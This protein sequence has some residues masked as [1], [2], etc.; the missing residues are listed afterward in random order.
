MI[1][2]V[3]LHHRLPCQE[4]SFL[5]KVVKRLLSSRK[6]ESRHARSKKGSYRVQLSRVW[7]PISE[8]GSHQ[9]NGSRRCIN[10]LS[11]EVFYRN[12]SYNMEIKVI[13]M[14][15]EAINFHQ[16]NV[17]LQAR[18]KLQELLNLIEQDQRR[19]EM[20][21]TKYTWEVVNRGRDIY[22]EENVK[23]SV[24]HGII[25]LDSS[26][27]GAQFY[28][29]FLN[30]LAA[31][32]LELS[33]FQIASAIF[34]ILINL[35]RNSSATSRGRD[36]AAAL[37]NRGCILMIMACFNEA[38]E[39]FL[40]ALELFNVEK[41]TY[42]YGVD[43]LILAVKNNISRLNMMLKSFEYLEK[44]EKLG[45]ECKLEKSDVPFQTVFTVMHNE[46]EMHI[47]L[48]NLS[49]AE[50]ELR[51]LEQYLNTRKKGKSDFLFEYTMLQLSKVLLL[52]GKERDAREVF[53][54]EPPTS[55]SVHKL[56]FFGSNVYVGIEVFEKILDLSVTSGK[57]K[58]ARELLDEGLQVVESAFGPDHFNV[59]SLL[60]KEGVI[61]KMMGEM[62][63][64]KRKLEKAVHI[65]RSI[66]GELHP[67]LIKCYMVLG[68]V[69]SHLKRS[70]EAYDYFQ[71]AIKNVE[72]VFKVS[73]SDQLFSGDWSLSRK[74]CYTMEQK[75]DRI[76]DLV[77]EYG[78]A[79]AVV[80]SQFT[81]R[82]AYRQ[83]KSK[84]KQ[85][86]VRRYFSTQHHEYIYFHHLLGSG[87]A[88]ARQGK[89]KEA[90]TFFQR[91]SEFSYRHNV[92]RSLPE[93]PLVRLYAIACHKTS[94]EETKGQIRDAFNSCFEEISANKRYDVGG[95]SSE[96]TLEPG[97]GL[98]LKVLLILII[99]LSLQLKMHD[100]TFEA[101]DLYNSL[102]QSHEEIFSV[103]D[104]I[105]VYASRSSLTCNG[106]TVLQ[107]FLFCSGNNF[108]DEV[109]PE[110]NVRCEPLYKSLASKKNGSRHSLLASYTDSNFLDIEDLKRVEEK[111]LLS[112]KAVC[113]GLCL[114][115]DV[116]AT[117][118]VVDLSLTSRF[119]VELPAL[120]SCRIELLPLCLTYGRI[121]EEV[122]KGK[123]ICEI[124]P[125][126]CEKIT[127]IAFLDE[128]MSY[129]MFSRIGI[130]LLK[131]CDSEKISL[132]VVQKQC[133]VI[134]I[135][136]PF[137]VRLVLLHK[138]NAIKLNVQAVSTT[139]MFGK[140]EAPG[141]F[142]F[143]VFQKYN[144]AAFLKT[145]FHLMVTETSHELCRCP[146]ACQTN[147]SSPRE[148]HE[149]EMKFLGKEETYTGPFTKETDRS[150]GFVDVN[151]LEC[152][153]AIS[154]LSW[155]LYENCTAHE[156]GNAFEQDYEIQTDR[157]SHLQDES[158]VTSLS[159]PTMSSHQTERISSSL[160]NVT[161]AAEKSPKPA[162]MRGHPLA[163][164]DRNDESLDDT[165]KAMCLNSDAKILGTKLFEEGKIARGFVI[166]QIQEGLRKKE[167]P[168]QIN[169]FQSRESSSGISLEGDLSSLKDHPFYDANGCGPSNNALIK[170]NPERAL[171]VDL[172]SG[173]NNH[174]VGAETVREG[175]T[176]PFDDSDIKS[177][178]HPI[179][180]DELQN[181][182]AESVQ[183]LPL[184]ISFPK[185]STITA[186]K[187]Y[188]DASD[189][190]VWQRK[191]SDEISKVTSVELEFAETCATTGVEAFL[192]SNDTEE[193]HFTEAPAIRDRVQQKSTSLL[194]CEAFLRKLGS[195][196][197]LSSSEHDTASV[198]NW[199]TPPESV[200][201]G[202]VCVDEWSLS[203][204]AFPAKRTI[205]VDPTPSNFSRQVL[206]CEVEADCHT[207]PTFLQDEV[208]SERP[209]NKPLNFCT[210]YG[211]QTTTPGSKSVVEFRNVEDFKGESD[212]SQSFTIKQKLVGISG[213]HY[214]SETANR[215]SKSFVAFIHGEDF[216]GESD[217]AQSFKTEQTLVGVTGNADVSSPARDMICGLRGGSPKSFEDFSSLDPLLI[218]ETEGGSV[219]L[220]PE[221]VERHS[222]TS[223]S[224]PS[225][226]TH[227]NSNLATWD[228]PQDWRSD[229][230]YSLPSFSRGASDV[231]RLRPLGSHRQQREKHSSELK[232]ISLEQDE[233]WH[234]P[235]L[236]ENYE[237]NIAAFQS[238]PRH[239]RCNDI[240]YS[241]HQPDPSLDPAEFRGGFYNMT[242]LMPKCVGGE[243]LDEY[244]GVSSVT[245][246]ALQ[247]DEG[248]CDTS[249]DSIGF[250]LGDLERALDR[251]LELWAFSNIETTPV[252][253]ERTPVEKFSEEEQ[254]PI[255]RE[256][257]NNESSRDMSSSS[258][259]AL[260]QE[261]EHASE[262][263][264]E[265]VRSPVQETPRPL[266][267]HYHRRCLV[268]FPCCNKFYPCHRCHNESDEC[269][270][271]QSRAVN[272]THLRCSICYNEQEVRSSLLSFIRDDVEFYPCNRIHSD[273]SYHCD[274]CNVCLDKRLLGNH[275]CRPDSGHDECCICLEDAFS[276]C[277]I[278]PCSHKVHKDCAIAMIENG[279]RSCPVCR[280]PLFQPVV[281]DT[282]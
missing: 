142:C 17:P 159:L 218:Q 172:S 3:V 57:F 226:C 22:F 108:L 147:Q 238:R 179:R 219:G 12:D 66:F 221:F 31:F 56:I 122:L 262:T 143:T 82:K 134:I 76:D 45:K 101:H 15:E 198:E 77:A 43:A 186:E 229:S 165:N 30:I 202:L 211:S 24:K 177:E 196:D 187:T 72:S 107:D 16:S 19:S 105:Q 128:T 241:I 96:D 121:S 239:L 106:E 237:D 92:K 131:Q 73:F 27:G 190:V 50:E 20:N 124:S 225:I 32:S 251:N 214:E 255:F 213:T 132:S 266:C 48:G 152:L 74:R 228:L 60:Y 243:I 41:E 64:S 139:D 4:P 123:T 93:A 51:Q 112:F 1:P 200:S 47:K 270:E 86:L 52:R 116:H 98:N 54:L 97:C 125:R 180:L 248:A 162:F 227:P 150:E 46:I 217:D 203:F 277:Q 62:H 278:L 104:Q 175:S 173:E 166:S 114:E 26:N 189:G 127:R 110:C 87:R 183:E 232:Q 75:F 146:S 222:V 254:T 109:H 205:C 14:F 90:E 276:G 69:A 197:S 245:D 169:S 265:S 182:M 130:W 199:T 148:M 259:T 144:A 138:G 18:Y 274:V 58:A 102:S 167:I 39:S 120:M 63:G 115:R 151:T 171:K 133:I 88:L 149:M 28:E 185:D 209:E 252:A 170:A 55:S 230:V 117:Q 65:V 164:P 83:G 111:T 91:A 273:K 71:R 201:N 280:H 193:L 163:N 215:G 234:F 194:T 155:C 160:A 235:P 118:V 181:E 94:P 119:G 99:I 59:A 141:N 195:A 223:T 13:K 204:E 103:T 8:N 206:D 6:D 10:R 135:T 156:E 184:N 191:A 145:K 29:S 34:S 192:S 256:N 113:G 268:K 216:K 67:L 79:L 70:D 244:S 36:L 233:S 267:G 42:D 246:K 49:K 264:G 158:F 282:E 207:N 208:I 281:S 25:I 33:E 40:G 85:P 153:K 168:E 272:A 279:V 258:E 89:M 249:E 2:L 174:L 263:V 176:H 269:P 250:L 261:N 126:V 35:H 81:I 220:H 231:E 21:R 68:D 271:S 236:P 37:N 275:K 95:G 140:E 100:T 7:S 61:L 157:Q 53:A 210:H 129:V 80:F 253:S 136:D 212:D 78:Q 240:E 5:A 224:T 257:E 38:T 137:K 11:E 178:S 44:L 23:C 84:G 247:V 188:F 242:P 154:E 260:Q 9:V 161:S